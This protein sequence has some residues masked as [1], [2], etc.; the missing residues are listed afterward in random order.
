MRILY[1]LGNGFDLQLDLK[2]RYED[3]Y[4]Y[5]SKLPS[6]DSRIKSL[7]DHINNNNIETRDGK[8]IDW[9]DLEMAL[10]KYTEELESYEDLR[11]IYL[12]IN[13][14]L[15]NY[16]K[17]QEDLLK[18]DEQF[19]SKLKTDLAIP[20]QYL[21]TNGRLGY[22]ALISAEPTQLD[23]LTFN[24]TRCFER[25][26]GEGE[27]GL[28]SKN[29]KTTVKDVLHIHG[30]LS[31]PNVLIGVNDPSQ[32]ANESLR[33]DIN[34]QEM[35]IKPSTND[36]LD[37]QRN[38]KFINKIRSAQIIIIYGASLGDSDKVWR[39]LLAE[40][41]EAKNVYVLIFEQKDR[42]ENL[43]DRP[44]FERNARKSFLSKLGINENNN[45]YDRNIFVAVTREMFHI[46]K[47]TLK[48]R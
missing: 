38:Q 46:D 7:K 2:T 37:V 21:S 25:I 5:Y 15:I 48:L 16:L 23:I 9:S 10:G 41:L 13:I 8:I 44:I 20:E 36:M 27:I 32:I 40:R 31:M 29:Y 18:K 45:H 11:T 4:K 14:A 12:D 39:D 3:F 17:T 1:L 34:I 30:D 22:S 19:F 47:P 43:Y 6:S 42:F 28:N 24:Y 33:E 26:F 35:L